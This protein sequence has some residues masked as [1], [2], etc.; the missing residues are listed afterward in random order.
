[1][2][3][4]GHPKIKAFSCRHNLLKLARHIIVFSSQPSLVTF[5]YQSSLW[6]GPQHEGIT[7]IWSVLT[8]WFQQIEIKA[9]D[10]WQQ[11]DPSS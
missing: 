5:H 6:K 11:E 2:F 7:S 9:N 8:Q 4:F 10:F 3:P 1:M